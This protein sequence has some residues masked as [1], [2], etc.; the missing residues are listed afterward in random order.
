MIQILRLDKE[1][2]RVQVPKEI[3]WQSNL[4]PPAHRYNGAPDGG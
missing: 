2:A 3:K 4:K 1:V